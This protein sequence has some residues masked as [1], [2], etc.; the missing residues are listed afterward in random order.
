MVE[1]TVRGSAI[2]ISGKGVGILLTALCALLNT[3]SGS[4][5]GV[6]PAEAMAEVDAACGLESI[7]FRTTGAV[8]N[9][10]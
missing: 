4:L 9:S 8:E 10:T 1:T 5:V 3:E 7:G 2:K 6:T